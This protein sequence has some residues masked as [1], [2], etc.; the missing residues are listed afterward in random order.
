[1]IK[2][3]RVYPDPLLLSPCRSVTMEEAEP[4]VVDLVDTMRS[5][6][7][8]VGLAAPQIGA[9]VRVAVVDCSRHPAASAH[10][11]LVVLVDPRILKAPGREV[12]REG[13][14]SLPTY[15]VDVARA[16]R[17]VVEGQPGRLLWA[18]GF[19]ARAIQHEMDHLDGVLILDR[20]AGARAVHR[21][22]TGGAP[23]EVPPR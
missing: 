5:L 2:P 15:T 4:V 17:I 20:A 6:T 21:R 9:P 7:R 10:N 23:P 11:G 3:V 16:R 14:Q 8:C 13:C 12:G 22:G 19:E 18:A 1:L